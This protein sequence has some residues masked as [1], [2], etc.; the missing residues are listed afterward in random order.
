MNIGAV[1]IGSRRRKSLRKRERVL[2]REKR[3]RAGEKVSYEGVES[4]DGDEEMEDALDCEAMEKQRIEQQEQEEDDADS[5]YG[6][7][8]ESSFDDTESVDSNGS[9]LLTGS[10]EILDVALRPRTPEP[11]PESTEEVDSDSWSQASELE[12]GHL[13]DSV[14]YDDNSDEEDTFDPRLLR[15]DDYM[16]IN[17]C[18]ALA[19]NDQRKAYISGR[20]RYNDY[21]YFD[22]M[23]DRRDPNDPGDSPLNLT[24]YNEGEE[25]QAFPF[26]EACFDIL[27]K[28]IGLDKGR[29]VDR[30]VMWEVI[31]AHLG[32][33]RPVLELDY[34]I[35][36]AQ[37]Q[38]W[39]N[40]PGQEYVVC[41]PSPHP[42]LQEKIQDMLPANVVARTSAYA[43][44]TRKV[45]NDPTNI[46]PY[47]TILE[48]FGYMNTKDMKSFMRA[49]YH[50]HSSTRETAFWKH[51]VRIRIL[52]W[53][54]ELRHFLETISTDALDYK[55]LFLWADALTR[56]EFGNQGPLMH[57]ANRRRIWDC[58]QPLASLCKQCPCMN[59][60]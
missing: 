26:H 31:R 19:I 8:S 45:R 54:Y 15:L 22:V 43:N 3:R 16:W 41:D 34:K 36:T 27:A 14:N 6:Y 21:G 35:G 17:R 29:D 23:G 9:D 40:N 10:F 53:F 25:N 44:L 47:D 13:V 11:E 56:P 20:G 32:D 4:D 50:I 30:D 33:Q 60:T 51:M 38:F 7:S 55:G 5:D 57:V 58:C 37:E 18:R 52:P 2:D 1:R 12:L 42:A 48:I 24:S 59:C 28:S 46:L 49:S 39:C